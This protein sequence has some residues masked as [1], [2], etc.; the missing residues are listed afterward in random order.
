MAEG[1]K[2]FVEPQRALL[3]LIAQK[4]A[5]QLAHGSRPPGPGSQHT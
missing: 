4:R 3:G 1:I 2:K 5:A